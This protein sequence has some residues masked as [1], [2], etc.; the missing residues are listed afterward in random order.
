M[1]PKF[2]KELRSSIETALTPLLLFLYQ[3]GITANHLTAVQVLLFAPIIYSICLYNI[4]V[5]A[6]LFAITLLFDTLDGMHARVTKTTS[7]KGHLYDK[8]VD[9]LSIILFLVGVS[10]M[11]PEL[12]SLSALLMVTTLILYALHELNPSGVTFYGGVRAIGDL[13]IFCGLLRTGL[14][15]SLI[16]SGV[17]IAA[18]LWRRK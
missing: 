4:I 10:F 1:K 18:N 12:I 2:V 15:I 6:I 5:F 3:R 7:R 8:V 13:A 11:I 9:L 16:L 14:I 17:S